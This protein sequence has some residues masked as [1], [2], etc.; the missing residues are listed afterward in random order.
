M[1]RSHIYASLL[2]LAGILILIGAFIVSNQAPVSPSAPSNAWG[3]GVVARANP[4]SN[5]VGD[6]T[7]AN[8]SLSGKDYTYISPFRKASQTAP[9][10]PDDTLDWQ[11]LQKQ[12]TKPTAS[13]KIASDDSS[14]DAYSFIPTGLTAPAVS[15]RPQTEAARQLY[16][17][18]NGIGTMIQSYEGNHA[19]QAAILTD[20]ARERTS[21][22]KQAAMK[23]LGDDLAAVG[24]EMD[25]IEPAPPEIGTTAHTLADSYREI[26]AKL[27]LIPDAK[28]D[29]DVG[30]A[31]LIYDASAE[32]FVR[33]YIALAQ[34]F[35]A[36]GISFGKDEP[37]S[38]F[39]MP[40]N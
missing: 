32:D 36:H 25:S 33:K 39:M 11:A 26:G 17:Y 2:S 8:P 29:A 40:A 35:Q 4:I 34:I 14:V 16:E 24:D 38:V 23:K 15:V 3:S 12:L 18:G 19:N 37:G 1:I 22:S 20:F 27:A 30:Q 31:M 13:T 28:T 9:K 7:P 6:P 21:A 10:Q 5:I